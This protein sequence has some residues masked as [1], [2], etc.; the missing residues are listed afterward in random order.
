MLYEKYVDPDIY[1]E[2]EAL[3]IV[4]QVVT[5]NSFL[6]LSPEIDKSKG[7]FLTYMHVSTFLEE[8]YV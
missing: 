7:K 6:N 1:N 5:T 4:S 2:L 8:F 3:E